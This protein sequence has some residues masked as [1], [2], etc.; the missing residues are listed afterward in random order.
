[1]TKLA[2]FRS[3]RTLSACMEVFAGE[4]LV[5]VKALVSLGTPVKQVE[6]A[7]LPHLRWLSIMRIKALL[8]CLQIDIL[9]TNC[10]FCD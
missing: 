8:G 2:G 10:F 1:M 6:L 4:A 7:Q 9:N 5:K 3:V